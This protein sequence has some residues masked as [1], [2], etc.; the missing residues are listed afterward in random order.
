M[1]PLHDDDDDDDYDYDHDYDDDDD[2][3]MFGVLQLV[4]VMRPL[5]KFHYTLDTSLQL[6]DTISEPTS[7]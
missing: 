5:Y 6:L 7:K 2:D 4:V 3:N 1:R